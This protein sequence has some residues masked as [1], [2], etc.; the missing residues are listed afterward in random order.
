MLLLSIR[1]S[2]SSHWHGSVKAK[3]REATAMHRFATGDKEEKCDNEVTV[4]HQLCQF[5]ANTM[6]NMGTNSRGGG[7]GGVT[8]TP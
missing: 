7:G 1:Q 2:Q 6:E 8:A 5:E 4:S 3:Q